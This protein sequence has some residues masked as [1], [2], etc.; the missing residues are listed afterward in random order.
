MLVHTQ[1]PTA[2]N[3]LV[4]LPNYYLLHIAMCPPTRNV[5]TQ[6]KIGYKYEISALADGGPRNWVCTR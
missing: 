6:V 2:V 1:H 3:P 5:Y 4:T